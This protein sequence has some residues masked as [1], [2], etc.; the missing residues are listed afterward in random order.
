MISNSISEAPPASE[1]TSPS[2]H[3]ARKLWDGVLAAKIVT[4]GLAMVL[5]VKSIDYVN[6]YSRGHPVND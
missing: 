3:Q 2:A 4:Y 5:N 1:V 6:P